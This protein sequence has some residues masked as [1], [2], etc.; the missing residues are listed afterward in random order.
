MV[1]NKS[2]NPPRALRI[3]WTSPKVIE[4]EKEE[5]LN[6]VFNYPVELCCH[7]LVFNQNIENYLNIT[8]KSL[9]EPKFINYNIS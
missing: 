1:R 2:L 4:S 8:P 6:V 7:K 3:M 9:N 5:R